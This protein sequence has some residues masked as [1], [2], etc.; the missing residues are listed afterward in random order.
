MR[1]VEPWERPHA[2]RYLLAFLAAGLSGTGASLLVNLL[3][4]WVGWSSVSAGI[5]SLPWMVAGLLLIPL[6]FH[7]G[8]EL[9]RQRQQRL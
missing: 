7:K 6:A 1:R 9:E 3:F 8:A 4:R 5:L 2:R